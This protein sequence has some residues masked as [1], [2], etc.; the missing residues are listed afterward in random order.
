MAAW[1]CVDHLWTHHQSKTRSVIA[2]HH[3]SPGFLICG[4]LSYEY[5]VSSSNPELR[6][7]NGRQIERPEVMMESYDPLS[8]C[9]TNEHRG[10]GDRLVKESAALFADVGL[11]YTDGSG[12]D[13][14]VKERMIHKDRDSSSVYY[15]GTAVATRR[16]LYEKLIKQGKMPT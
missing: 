10:L 2:Y 9:W 11:S 15:M 8:E 1:C 5:M 7:V 14:L 4:S 3:C 6:Q 16:V 13:L 12:S